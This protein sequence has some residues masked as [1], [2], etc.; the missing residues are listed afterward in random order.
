MKKTWDKNR[1]G[2]DFSKLP[3]ADNPIFRAELKHH[4]EKIQLEA[5]DIVKEIDFKYIN[6]NPLDHGWRH[7]V[8]TKYNSDY[9]ARVL[10]DNQYIGLL[11]LGLSKGNHFNYDFAAADGIFKQCRYI[12]KPKDDFRVLFHLIIR[13]SDA[14]IYKD[15]WLEMRIG[16]NQP[17]KFIGGFDGWHYYHVPHKLGNEWLSFNI[18]I[19][20]A[21]RDTFGTED[22]ELTHLI[23]I[24]LRG[25]ADLA[26]I[27]LLA[28]KHSKELNEFLINARTNEI[29]IREKE[30]R[31]TL[32][33]LILGF[34]EKKKPANKKFRL[35][36]IFVWDARN[37][38]SALILDE[39]LK[40][41]EE[42]FLKWEGELAARNVIEYDPQL[43]SKFYKQKDED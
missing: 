30:L 29:E 18:D 17:H 39:L 12:V 32:R 28:P 13:N 31:K 27:Q 43:I 3:G 10:V 8:D 7:G 42:G 20:K 37:K 19:E 38:P 40:L 11:Y 33:E 2:I 24:R 23:G 1:Y 4:A 36:D 14:T 25:N 22:Y 34:I 21:V 6:E 35:L 41:K 9:V 5:N 26:K 16:A 15:G